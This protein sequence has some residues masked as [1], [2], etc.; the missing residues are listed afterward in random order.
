MVVHVYSATE[1]L[2]VDTIH[3]ASKGFHM[4]EVFYVCFYTH[5]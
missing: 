2:S 3:F 4:P 1:C 5:V